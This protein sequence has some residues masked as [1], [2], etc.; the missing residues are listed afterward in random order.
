MSD[1]SHCTKS[2]TNTKHPLYRGI[3]R[4]SG[5]WVSEIREPRKTTRI[6]LGTYPTPQM[7]AAAYDVA[8]LALKGSDNVVLNFPHH[9]N[10]Y[11]ELSSSPSPVD[12]RRAAAAAAEAMALQGDDD[13]ST[14]NRSG[15][16]CDEGGSTESSSSENYAMQIGNTQM[17][18][19]EEEF[20]DEEALFGF[21]S[22]LVNMADAMM[23]SPPRINSS[24]FEDYSAGDFDVE[25]LWSY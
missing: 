23:L 8:A 12:I 5:K 21:P 9:V 14:G 11:P 25:S 7:A 6:W 3:R 13:W 18:M 1:P 16:T 15:A 19:G 17:I 24:Y 4:R 20:V 2:R 10:S 22:L